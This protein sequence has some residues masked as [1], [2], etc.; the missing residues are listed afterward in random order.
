MTPEKVQFFR[1]VLEELYALTA[2]E[3]KYQVI[4]SM[5][6]YLLP[7]LKDLNDD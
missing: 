4:H 3:K 7:E 1:D 5:I 6:N 2:N